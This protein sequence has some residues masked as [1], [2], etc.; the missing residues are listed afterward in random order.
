MNEKD[1]EKEI[2]VELPFNNLFLN[3]GFINGDNS[4]GKYVSTILITV[5]AYFTYQILML[6]ILVYFAY[7][8]G[9]DIMDTVTLQKVIMN[10][11]ALGISKNFMLALLL[12]M[13]AFT[14]W[15]FYLSVKKI[16]QKPFISIITAY[17]HIRWSR[18]FFAFG[19]WTFFFL[20]MFLVDYLWISP[21]NYIFNF[22][23]KK[24]TVLFIVSTLLL[25][26]QSS[27]EELFFRGYL[28]QGLSLISKN[29]ILPLLF[30]SLL[31]GM[32]HM[33]NPE[34]EEFGAAMMLPY[35]SLF[36]LFLGLLALWNNGLELSMGIH[37]ANNIMSSLLITSD[38]TVLQTDALFV[39]KHQ[40]PLNDF[41]LWI[42][43]A[44][45]TLFVFQYKY[46]FKNHIQLLK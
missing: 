37:V 28:M 1:N 25:P 21:D 39:V 18:F 12:G 43:G 3:A 32:A 9:I 5:F 26:I 42:F 40:N 45:F 38:S 14:F 46:K 36:G 22:D 8:N 4:I 24:F 20:S 27:F 13:F 19:V 44:A 11:D 6:G 17:P 41:V 23:A 2:K 35:Y 31:F 34:A 10:P 15:A 16:H 7:Q 30:T 29:G 33:S